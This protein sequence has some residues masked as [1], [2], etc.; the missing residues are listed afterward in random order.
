MRLPV[1]AVLSVMSVAS[2]GAQE[3]SLFEQYE[4]ARGTFLGDLWMEDY[5]AGLPAKLL[6]GLDGTWFPIGSLKPEAEDAVIFA[7]VCEKMPVT[8]SVTS[9]WGFSL[10][11]RTGQ[12]TSTTTYTARGGNLFGSHTDPVAELE[13]FGVDPQEQPDLVAR[14]LADRNG[15]ATVTRPSADILVIQAG[16]Q[17]PVIYARCDAYLVR[18]S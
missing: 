6:D 10:E 18:A 17:M 9:D 13:R 3:A 15:D 1:L 4:D 14:I 7:Q 11:A 12:F 2:V 16:Q 8:L 5:A